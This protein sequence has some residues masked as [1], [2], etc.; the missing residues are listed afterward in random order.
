MFFSWPSVIEPLGNGIPF[1]T[2]AVLGEPEFL[3]SCTSMDVTGTGEF[4]VAVTTRTV[5]V[6]AQVVVAAVNVASPVETPTAEALPTACRTLGFEDEIVGIDIRC[7]ELSRL[8]NCRVI[9]CPT[10]TESL[11]IDRALHFGRLEAA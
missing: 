11:L 9:D 8:A 7:L 1:D 2:I 5:R 4:G 6:S 10:I 3:T